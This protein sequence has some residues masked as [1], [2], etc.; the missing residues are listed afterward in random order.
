VAREGGDRL[1]GIDPPPAAPRQEHA[2]RPEIVAV[3]VEVQQ[4]PGVDVVVGAAEVVGQFV[5]GHR[6]DVLGL[7]QDVGG[8]HARTEHV[9]PLLGP[10]PPD[11]V[12]ERVGRGLV[13]PAE[14]WVH[15]RRHPQHDSG[16]W[17]GAGFADEGQ[18]RGVDPAVHPALVEGPQRHAV[19][20]EQPRHR[21]RHRARVQF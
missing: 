17:R 8:V 4:V 18:E 9:A 1:A 7:Q 2:E 16:R 21:R 20:L 5:V 15:A 10:R 3:E 12:L 19:A 11:A 14:R 6:R 13:A